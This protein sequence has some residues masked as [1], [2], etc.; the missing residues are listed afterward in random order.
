M[1]SPDPGQGGSLEA[2]GL[3]IS[4]FSP[5]PFSTQA[6]IPDHPGLPCPEPQLRDH[7]QGGASSSTLG[8]G[9]AGA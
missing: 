8:Q 6:P 9:A 7:T 1:V 4:E 3:S 5:W 2:E